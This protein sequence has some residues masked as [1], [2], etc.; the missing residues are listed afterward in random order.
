MFFSKNPK[1]ILGVFIMYN[2]NTEI[3]MESVA[4][5]LQD[6]VEKIKSEKNPEVLDDF[7]FSR[8]SLFERYFPWKCRISFLIKYAAT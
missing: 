4:A 6:T 3:D 8:N 2:R 7:L 1:L 5:F